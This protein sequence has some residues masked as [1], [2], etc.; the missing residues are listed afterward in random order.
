[1]A[2]RLP[3]KLPRAVKF[4][5]AQMQDFGAVFKMHR[6]VKNPFAPPNKS[7]ALERLDYL[8]GGMQTLAVRHGPP[9]LVVSRVHSQ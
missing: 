1:M 7:V 2:P 9:F 8:G 6:V 3:I 5:S 4:D